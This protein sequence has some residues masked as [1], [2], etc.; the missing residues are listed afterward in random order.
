M[1]KAIQMVACGREHSMALTRGGSIWCW[2]D[3]QQGQLG[4]GMMN[5]NDYSSSS[6]STFTFPGKKTKN[7]KLSMQEEAKQIELQN[8]YFPHAAKAKERSSRNSQRS[9]SY[10]MQPVKLPDVF[11][12]ASVTQIACGSWHSICLTHRGTSVKK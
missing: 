6:S 2:G 12:G 5:E 7:L 4:L 9:K 8:K 10:V 3:N 1:A 11:S